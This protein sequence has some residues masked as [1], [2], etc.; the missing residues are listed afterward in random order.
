[1]SNDPTSTN[2][3]GFSWKAASRFFKLKIYG[4]SL[5]SKSTEQ[6]IFASQI[7]I[8][9]M[10]ASEAISWAYFGSQ[11]GYKNLWYVT[12]AFMGIS[13]FIIIWLI[14]STFMTLDRYKRYYHEKTYVLDQ[15]ANE[16][17]AS[18][19]RSLW[20]KNET[21]VGIL[22]RV[23]IIGISMYF[24]AG[25]LTDLF[26]HSEINYA[27]EKYTNEAIAKG[28]EGLES[29]YS[30]VDSTLSKELDSLNYAY[31]LEV[32][33][34]GASERYGKGDAAETIK[35]QIEDKKAE[36]ALNLSQR[37][38]ELERYDTYAAEDDY[39][40]LGQI[41]GIDVPEINSELKSQVKEPILE[42]KEGK[43]AEYAI[44]GFLGF[45][46]LSL[47]LLKLF[48]PRGV[49]IYLSDALQQHYKTYLDGGFN[50]LIRNPLERSKNGEPQMQPFRFE[51]FMLTTYHDF[52]Y[53]AHNDENR[54]KVEAML[55]QIEDRINQIEEDKSKLY[56]ERREEIEKYYSD[57][58]RL[59]EDLDKCNEEIS[60]IKDHFEKV[61]FE[62][63]ILTK[64]I[65]SV[66]SLIENSPNGSIGRK[67]VEGHFIEVD[68]LTR[69]KKNH[70][71]SLSKFKAREIELKNSISRKTNEKES[72]LEK[73][74][75]LEEPIKSLDERIKSWKKQRFDLIEERLQKTINK[76]R[77]SDV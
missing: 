37:D 43:R 23:F 28:R 38:L 29:T 63:D 59:E 35:E 30:K 77:E 4:G 27:I 58:K 70:K 56:E 62:I 18:F 19:L 68:K 6:W 74:K 21:K 10:A 5:I 45:I 25:Y 14:D 67:A 69:E 42:S 53:N 40:S 9:L 41:W 57:I 13:V 76:V 2:S 26:F 72:V 39:E 36:I 48:E 52:I 60:S 75:I 55:V 49:R 73:I 20:E 31:T 65:S 17:G 64:E 11:F 44:K 15:E 24:T 71:E 46:F 16:E 12:A 1:M 54:L 8:F 61:G 33:G 50:S 34:K 3:K 47:M 22:T 51:E 7:A 66:N 32:A